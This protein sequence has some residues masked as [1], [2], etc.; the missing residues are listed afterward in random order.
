MIRPAAVMPIQSGR[1]SQSAKRRRSP[2]LG[3]E[4]ALAMLSVYKRPLTNAPQPTA[5]WSGRSHSDRLGLEREKPTSRPM[6][7]DGRANAENRLGAR[8][9]A[10]CERLGQLQAV[11]CLGVAVGG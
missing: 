9:E 11:H 3:W 6:L 1:G 4:S 2:H 5:V 10:V 7:F 8:F